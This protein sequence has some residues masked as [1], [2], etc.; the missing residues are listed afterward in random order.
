MKTKIV[1]LSVLFLSLIITTNVIAQKQKSEKKGKSHH[2]CAHM[3]DLT[4]AQK[5][6]IEA[7]HLQKREKLVEYRAEVKIKKAELDKMR[8]STITPEKEINAKVDEIAVIKANM[9]KERISAERAIMK[10]LTPEQQTKYKSQMLHKG[11][12]SSKS[13]CT[14]GEMHQKKEMHKDCPHNKQRQ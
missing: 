7:I 9:Q 2:A 13:G 3:D 14:H 1:Y 5:S 4:D 6:K 10:E 12:R 8:L 11:S